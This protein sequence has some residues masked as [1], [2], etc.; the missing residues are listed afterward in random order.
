[1][2]FLSL[3]LGSILLVLICVA[4]DQICRLSVLQSSKWALL[5]AL[6]DNVTHGAVG[7]LS[8]WLLIGIQWPLLPASS[9]I[10]QSIWVAFI[11]SAIDLDHFVAA[12]SLNI[13]DVVRLPHRPPLHC[14]GLCVLALA[15]LTVCAVFYPGMRL[16][17]C[18]WLLA[19]A[20]HH[21]RDATRR[22]LWLIPGL[23]STRPLP[24]WLYLALEVA[25][26][27]LVALV[28]PLD[29]KTPVIS[30]VNSLTDT[31]FV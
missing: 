11:A 2:H 26:A 16:L 10:L 13:H 15:A 4:G 22:G 7:G 17:P 8:W 5:R 27:P 28:L 24:Y 19:F 30:V 21:V 18:Q 25:A 9:R 12:G 23:W 29:F 3:V 31:S 20:T 6:A 14:T 1:M